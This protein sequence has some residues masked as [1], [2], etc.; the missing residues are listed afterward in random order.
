MKV[1]ASARPLTARRRRPE[2]EQ[3]LRDVDAKDVRPAPRKQRRV[4]AGAAPEIDDTLACHLPS[5]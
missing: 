4:R 2:A 1:A 5:W 3:I